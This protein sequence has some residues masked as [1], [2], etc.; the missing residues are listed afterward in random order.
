[1]DAIGS[2]L[3]ILQ[4]RFEDQKTLHANQVL[5][6]GDYD[7]QTSDEEIWGYDLEAKRHAEADKKKGVITN[8]LISGAGKLQDEADDD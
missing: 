3:K 7:D 5:L 4:E 8:L 6:T 1:M 2:N